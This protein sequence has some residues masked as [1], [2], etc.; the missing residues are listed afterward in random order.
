MP[1][2][3]VAIALT[4][5]FVFVAPVYSDLSMV[6]KEIA[7][8]DEAL[9]NSKALKAE[10]DKLTAKYNSFSQEDLDKLQK[11]LPENVDNIRLIL[12][13]EQLASPYGMVL[14]DVKYST[15]TGTVASGAN[16]AGL[17]RQVPRKDYG[18]LDL[19]FTTTGSYGNFLGFIRDLEN[20][21]RLVDIA[22]ID[23]SSEIGVSLNKS[24]SYEVYDYHIK[25]RTY[26]LKN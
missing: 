24:I 18:T 19:E 23:F 25:I 3:L 5:F 8:Y 17:G 16:G 22:A 4:L 11:L 1:V 20:N 13:I 14:R 2:I 21:L 10:R 12:E 6:R 9:G 7:A 26:W 15:D